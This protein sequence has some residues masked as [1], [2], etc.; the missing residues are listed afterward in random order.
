MVNTDVIIVGVGAA[1]GIMAKE[2][3]S[4]GLNVVGLEQGPELTFEQYGSKDSLGRVRAGRDNHNVGGGVTVWTGSTTRFMPGDFQVYT[5]EVEGGVAEK[6]GVD[7][8]GYD[9]VDWPI[10]YDDLEPYYERFEWEMGVSGTAG[11]NPFEGHRRRGYPLPA[12]REGARNRLIGDAAQRLGYHPYPTPAGILSQPYQPP[13]PYDTRIPLR[14]ACAYCGQCNNYGCHVGA[15]FSP[16]FT[17]LPVAIE[18]GNFNLRTNA[19]VF[20]INTDAKG[21]ASSVSYFDNNGTVQ[22]LSA[23]VV[24]LSAFSHEQARLLLLSGD[25]KRGIANSSGQVGRGMMAHRTVQTMG[26]FE[27]YEINAYI[28]PNAGMRMDDFNGNNFDHTGLGFIRGA[29]IGTSGG[30]PPLEHYNSLP[31]GAPRWGSAYKKHLASYFTR[32]MELNMQPESLPHR[33]NLMDLDPVRKDKWG[34]PIPRVRISFRDNESKMWSYLADVG[35]RVMKEAGAS[36]YWSEVS[37]NSSRSTGG[38]RMGADP[39]TSVVNGY[40]QTH[41][42]DNLFVVGASVFPTMAGYAPTPTVSALAYRTAEH[43]GSRREL[44]S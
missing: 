8:T 32:S 20:R 26:Y 21:R 2:L 40:C 35:L 6:A 43:I 1:G 22:Q 5:N 33:D 39:K 29:T 16:V 17:S 36:L 12:I 19:K 23:S 10:S 28:G 14:A 30:G 15:K 34:L 38:V 31:P 7:L 9:V 27:D 41:D 37:P 4:T 11:S 42:I 18:T 13:P 3:S 24:I 25:G 44:F